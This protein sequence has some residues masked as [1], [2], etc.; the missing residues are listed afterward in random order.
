MSDLQ[1]FINTIPDKITRSRVVR[2]IQNY[3]FPYK[4]EVALRAYAEHDA[5]HYLFNQPFTKE[6]EKKIA[7]AE[8]KFNR[9]WFA[10]D[11]KYN[12]FFREEF[13]CSHITHK[14]IDEVALKLYE[15]YDDY[16]TN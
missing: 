3:K 15:V 5:L 2:E 7:W 6:G 9:G 16:E 13:D 12:Q 1:T 4:T 11:E 8:Y 10:V 14:M